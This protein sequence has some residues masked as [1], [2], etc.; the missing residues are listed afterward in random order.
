[1][2]LH[3]ISTREVF[4][5]IQAKQS[6]ILRLKEVL[7]I[8]GLSRSSVYK[9]I[10]DGHFPKSLSLGARRVGWLEADIENWIQSRSQN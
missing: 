9:F 10:E 7:Y 6:R 8:T 4:L 5:E 1:M 3:F 2:R